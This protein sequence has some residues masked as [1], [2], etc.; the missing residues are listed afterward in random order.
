MFEVAELKN[1][2][3]KADYD[4]EVSVIR[5]QLLDVQQKLES[6]GVPVLI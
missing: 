4:A 6:A 2:V 1:K 3:S 5:E